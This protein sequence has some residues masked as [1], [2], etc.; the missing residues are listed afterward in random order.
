M[1]AG[2]CIILLLWIHPCASARYNP[3]SPNSTKFDM[4]KPPPSDP[5]DLLNAAVSGDLITVQDIIISKRINTEV[6][7]IHGWTALNL[8]CLAGRLQIVR[9]LVAVGAD[10]ESCENAGQSPLGSASINGHTAIVQY[11][12]SL[13]PP[14]KINVMDYQGAQPIHYSAQY[15]FTQIC[16]ILLKS[17]ANVNAQAK[18]NGWT[19]LHAAAAGGFVDT[20]ELLLEWKADRHI[21]DQQG[22]QPSD[23]IGTTRPITRRMKGLVMCL[24][25]PE[26][27]ALDELCTRDDDD[28]ELE[29]EP[30]M[31]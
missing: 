17:G 18:S 19:P 24:L 12:L 5:L 11:L 13:N 3:P 8:A 6:R 16:E 2:F 25:E 21:Y 10:L 4:H 22:N 9:F 14:A 26:A 20:V 1:K 28:E 27:T 15:G 30:E 7:S 23:V 31:E 29:L